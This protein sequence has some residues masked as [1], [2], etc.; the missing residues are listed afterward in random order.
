MCL[1]SLAKY[2]RAIGETS[3]AN[4]TIH[5][6]ALDDAEAVILAY[7][8]RDIGTPVATAD[9]TYRYDGSGFLEIDDAAQVNSVRYST[10]ASVLSTSAWEAKKDGP[11]SVPYSYIELAP[12]RSFS[13]EMG[14]MYNLD[15]AFARGILSPEVDI[16]VNANWGWAVVPNDIQRAA[17]WTAAAYESLSTS[18]G[19]A[20][21]SESVADVSK[22]YSF[23]D[24][25]E[26]GEVED[27]P[28]RAKVI[29]DKYRRHVL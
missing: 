16:V 9:R 17:I 29:L 7:L 28:P 24:A 2:K 8:D 6:E 20:V 5:Q 18:E 10:S 21:T 19:G 4:D 1:V 22:T 15:Q 13:A 25:T 12:L 23:A 3:S 11:P 26:S 27:L 14:F